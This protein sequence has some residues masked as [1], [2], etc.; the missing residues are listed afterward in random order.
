L[1]A[2]L[3]SGHQADDAAKIKRQVSYNR[4]KEWTAQLESSHPRDGLAKVKSPK[5]QFSYS[6]VSH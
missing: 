2:Q 3:D 5:G 1:T 4:V 6:P